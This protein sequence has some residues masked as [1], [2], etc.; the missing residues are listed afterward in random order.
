MVVCEGRGGTLGGG[1]GAGVT[2]GE[3][4]GPKGS[5]MVV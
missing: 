5:P 4:R 3:G 1:R 2:D